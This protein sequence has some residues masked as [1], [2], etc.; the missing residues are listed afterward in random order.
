MSGSPTPTSVGPAAMSAKSDNSS[1]SPAT[2]VTQEESSSGPLD[3]NP[4]VEFYLN[5]C[6]LYSPTAVGHIIDTLYALEHPEVEIVFQTEWNWF[7]VICH[8]AD[9]KS[10]RLQF[11]KLVKEI[12][13]DAFHGDFS[14]LIGHDGYLKHGGVNNQWIIGVN[15][16]TSI[17]RIRAKNYDT[18]RY[19]VAIDKF[20]YKE[21]WEHGNEDGQVVHLDDFLTED[22]RLKLQSQHNVTITHDLTGN[23]LYIGGHDQVAV[24]ETQKKLRVMLSAKTIQISAGRFEHLLYAE[25]WDDPE[26]PFT[27]DMR[28]MTNIEPK[29][30]SS[31]LIDGAKVRNMDRAYER[32]YK[33]GVSIRLC[34]Y[35]M[36]KSFYVSTFGPSVRGRSDNRQDSTLG[37]HPYL[38][39]N[40]PLTSTKKKE[41]I[42]EVPTSPN[43]S[44]QCGIDEWIAGIPDSAA[45][46]S[47]SLDP[48]SPPPF[49]TEQDE[50]DYYSWIAEEKVAEEKLIDVDNPAPEELINL[51]SPRKPSANASKCCITDDDLVFDPF[52]ADLGY[53]T[54]L[55]NRMSVEHQNP[56]LDANV[57]LIELGD[58]QT[59]T[60][61]RYNDPDAPKHET[62]GQQ[63]QH[64]SHPD[65][66]D[67]DDASLGWMPPEGF[68]RD[69]ENALKRL[70]ISS[71]FR[72]GILQLKAEFGRAILG[73][74]DES[75]LAFNRPDVR[76]NGWRKWEILNK[77]NVVSSV[78]SPVEQRNRIHFTKILTCSGADVEDLIGM[79]NIFDEGKRLWLSETQ[80]SWTV[81]SFRCISVVENKICQFVIEIEDH[82]PASNSPM[83]MHINIKPVHP[84]HDEDGVTPLYVHAIRCNWDLRFM[85]THVDFK[86]MDDIFGQFAKRLFRGLE[87]KWDKGP[88]L[89]FSIPMSSVSI[90]HVRVLTKW[91]HLSPDKESA[92]EITEVEQLLLEQLPYDPS[93][94]DGM[95]RK[96]YHARP[97]DPETSKKMKGNGD[98]VRWYEAAVVSTVL[99]RSFRQNMFIV[100]GEKA[101]WEVTN[102]QASKSFPSLYQSVLTMIRL[103]DKI[104]GDND[105]G[106][107]NKLWDTVA[108]P[109]SDNPVVGMP[110]PRVPPPVPEIA[111]KP[112]ESLDAGKKEEQDDKEVK[113][114]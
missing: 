41:E 91:R 30:T 21:V 27:A 82:G 90:T 75:A 46:G 99:E 86:K 76:S 60:F 35:S 47:P 61:K 83:H 81:Y 108:R 110:K 73:D 40:R 43:R 103:M 68:E 74:V 100:P 33:M 109:N 64:G 67:L 85:L 66:I 28:Y 79:T 59:D 84:A 17:R 39:G 24:Y 54:N 65:L 92:L 98:P 77:L 107:G 113:Y 50:I 19:P 80:K 112:K 45:L 4:L 44:G 22:Q 29:L 71:P 18:Y 7:R 111:W 97:Y 16:V 9:Q 69:L 58:S 20:P 102:L 78:V 38:L 57:D 62:M 36:W 14:S 52:K 31:T 3:G 93:S 105:N 89:K 55:V 70:L 63:A 56:A 32:M 25:N 42:V 10:I 15:E 101:E 106:R 53:L 51:E 23:T 12:T 1:D 96:D 13:K 114:F 87:I 26:V 94:P 88:N 48:N 11:Y 72:A 104:G 8:D 6:W 49:D 34:E 2:S 95:L 5:T 37:N